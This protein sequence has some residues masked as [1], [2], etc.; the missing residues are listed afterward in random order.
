VTQGITGAR[1][2]WQEQLRRGALD[3]AILLAVSPG[4]KYGLAIIQYL[5]RFTDLVVSEGTIYPILG[6]LTR[7]ELLHAWWVEDEAPHARKYYRLTPSG[8]RRLAE[9]KA[10]WLAFAGKITRLMRAAEG[11]VDAAE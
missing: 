6:R 5:E 9:M 10:E 4:P 7:D 1:A 8:R 11:A 2:N 3:F